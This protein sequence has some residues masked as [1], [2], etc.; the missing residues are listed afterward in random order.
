MGGGDQFFIGRERYLRR[1]YASH[2]H[3]VVYELGS[4]DVSGYTPGSPSYGSGPG[5]G[6]PDGQLQC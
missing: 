3:D 4:M 2:Y 1:A 6:C 5:E